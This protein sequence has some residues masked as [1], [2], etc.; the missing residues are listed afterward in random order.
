MSKKRQLNDE[1]RE[2]TEKNL[3]NTKLDLEYL[4][5]LIKQTVVNL[6]VAPAIYK[7]QVKEMQVKLE[8]LNSAKQQALFNITETE[9]QLKEG[10]E[11]KE[12]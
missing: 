10:V 5:A 7:H 4:E 12:K 1:E 9:K 11:S 6:E 8:Q 3:I 2:F